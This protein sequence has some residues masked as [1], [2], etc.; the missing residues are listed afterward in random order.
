V[1]FEL[2][3]LSGTWPMMQPAVAVTPCYFN[4]VLHTRMLQ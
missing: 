1:F 4:I 3:L 2:L